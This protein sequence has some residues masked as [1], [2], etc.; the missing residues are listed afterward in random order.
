MQSTVL[1]TAG[2]QTKERS[3]LPRE[4]TMSRG[5]G[6]P[7]VM[8]KDDPWAPDPSLKLHTRRLPQSL[9]DNGSATRL[10]SSTGPLP[11]GEAGRRGG[12]PCRA[13]VS[14]TEERRGA[15]RSAL[16]LPPSPCLSPHLALTPR[17]VTAQHGVD[18]ALIASLTAPHPPCRLWPSMQQLV[19]TQ[20][21]APSA[22]PLNR[23]K[24]PYLAGSPLS[25]AG[26]SPD[27]TLE[28]DFGP[29]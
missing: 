16:A 27:V 9:W 3:L 7:G 19:G 20:A 14:K 24:E 5:R 18:T 11:A 10:A 2:G 25:P 1:G 22:A 17:V 15:L 8:T 12:S 13:P 21:L 29:F 26:N 28:S 4:V 23:F 6:V